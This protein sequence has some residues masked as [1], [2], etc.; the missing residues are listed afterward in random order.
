MRLLGLNCLGSVVRGLFAAG[1]DKVG[2]R[3]QWW[4]MESEQKFRSWESTV[5]GGAVFEAQLTLGQ[6]KSPNTTGYLMG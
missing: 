2:V 5:F 6:L 1:V 3:A 4:R